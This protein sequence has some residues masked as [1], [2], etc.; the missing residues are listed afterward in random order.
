[1]KLHQVVSIH[2]LVQ[3]WRQHSDKGSNAGKEKD[4]NEPVA[5]PSPKSPSKRSVQ[6]SE[7][8]EVAR[9]N[10]GKRRKTEPPAAGSAP[11]VPQASLPS[12]PPSPRITFRPRPANRCSS[13]GSPISHPE[14]GEIF[15]RYGTVY[16]NETF[17]CTDA[18]DPVR[19]L[20]LSRKTLLSDARAR[21]GNALADE[22]WEYTVSKRG[23]NGYTVKVE[24]T[25]TAVLMKGEGITDPQKPVAIE[26]AKTKGI[27]GLMT[28]TS[29]H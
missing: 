7:P 11:A 19:L 21:G 10:K 9:A 4:L 5:P 25:A 6:I 29:R 2:G 8:P 18:V 13:G 23:K 12:P 20:T 24:Y 22:V 16:V 1:M 17:E 28:V 26:I 3:R 14:L 15:R 27:N